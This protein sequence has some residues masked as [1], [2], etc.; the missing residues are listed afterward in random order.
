M[1]WRRIQTGMQVGIHLT[2]IRA[3]RQS[4][5]SEQVTREFISAQ[6]GCR[7]LIAP[8]TSEATQGRG[9]PGT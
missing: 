4:C 7:V 5:T 9:R 1:I 2:A 6:N 3:G 8:S